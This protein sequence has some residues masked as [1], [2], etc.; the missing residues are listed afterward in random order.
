MAVCQSL[1]DLAEPTNPVKNEID[2]TNKADRCVRREAYKLSRSPGSANDIAEA[3]VDKCDQDIGL[4]AVMGASTEALTP[5]SI[6]R[7]MAETEI[8]REGYLSSAKNWVIEGRA[9][10]CDLLFDQAG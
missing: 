3:A 7:Q 6:Q 9:G 10:R 8:D 2:Q 4:I 5:E 1:S